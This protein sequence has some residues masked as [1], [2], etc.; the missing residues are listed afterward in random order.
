[1]TRQGGNANRAWDI[2]ELLFDSHGKLDV[3]GRLPTDR[4]HVLKVYGSKE[5]RWGTELGA[6]F[7]VS[8]GTPLTKTVATVNQTDVFVEGRGSMGRSDILSQT[9]LMVAHSFNLSESKKVRV[10]FNMINLF[11]QKTSRHRYNFYNRGG[12][13]IARSSSAINL[14]NVDLFQ[15]YDYNAL[16]ANTPDGRNPNLG[17]LDPRFGKDDIWNPGFQGRFGIKFTF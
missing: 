10:E 16:I 11:N 8:S 4:P 1:M 13:G 5:F 17:A 14:A 7:N 3:R 15:G 2:D 12:G 9:D 6:F